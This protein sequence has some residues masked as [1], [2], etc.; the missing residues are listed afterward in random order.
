[1]PV[2]T[3]G[4]VQ[5][6]RSSALTKFARFTLAVGAAIQRPSQSAL[7]VQVATVTAE[8]EPRGEVVVEGEYSEI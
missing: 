5:M 1:M 3:D 6:M 2:I 4:Q 7:G 8:P